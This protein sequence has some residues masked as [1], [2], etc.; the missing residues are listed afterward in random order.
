M[1]PDLIPITIMNFYLVYGRGRT[2]TNF[3]NS[4]FW[5]TKTFLMKKWY[6]WGSRNIPVQTAWNSSRLSGTFSRLSRKTSHWPEIFRTVWKFYRLSGSLLSY[7]EILQTLWK[8]SRLSKKLP[9]CWKIFLTVW[10]IFQT[11]H[12]SS[13]QSGNLQNCLK[14]FQT[15]WKFSRLSRVQTVQAVRKYYM[16][17]YGNPSVSQ[18]LLST[19]LQASKAPRCRIWVLD[20]K[21]ICPWVKTWKLASTGECLKSWSKFHF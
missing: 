20:L 7:L 16:G 18:I 3:P 14:I 10:K 12:K 9:G 17:L 15:I 13:R 19:Q 8:L 5:W 6:I 2:H 21:D 1:S 11:L 4:R